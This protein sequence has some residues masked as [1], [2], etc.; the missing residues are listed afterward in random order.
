VASQ[1]AKQKFELQ[2]KNIEIVG[3][4]PN[5]Y[6]LQKKGHSFEYLREIA[7][8]RPRSNTFSA[9][10]RVRSLLAFAIH[11]FFNEQGFIY[12][13]TPLITGSDAEGAGEMFKVSTLD[14]LNPPKTPDGAVD[15]TKDFFGK[16]ASL[17]VS[18]QLNAETFATAFNKVY[19]F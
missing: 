8:L 17:T 15:Y 2:A 11:K 4:S 12:V 19:T 18:G 14:M 7:H 9:V 1:G 13:H 6:P 3:I 16:E 10:F 5:D